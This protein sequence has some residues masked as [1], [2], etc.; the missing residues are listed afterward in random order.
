MYSTGHTK[1]PLAPSEK[2]VAFHKKYT[3][4]TLLEF[5]ATEVKW[6]FMTGTVNIRLGF[7]MSGC[8]SELCF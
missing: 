1:C 3:M 7:H 2:P 5:Y 6:T 4:E 8:V